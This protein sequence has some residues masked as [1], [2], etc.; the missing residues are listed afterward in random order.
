MYLKGKHGREELE[1]QER[2]SRDGEDR[3][4]VEAEPLG[5]ADLAL[6]MAQVEIVGHVA[7]DRQQERGTGGDDERKT[8]GEEQAS[9]DSGDM[10]FSG[11]HAHRHVG[12]V[13][14]RH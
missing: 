14:A 13:Q 3:E 12:I 10:A 9:N 1:Q 11:K 2:K 7:A 6:G 8:S 5:V 4:A